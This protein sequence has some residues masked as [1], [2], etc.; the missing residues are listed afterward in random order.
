MRPLPPSKVPSLASS[1][2]SSPPASIASFRSASPASEDEHVI[3]RVRRS[4]T[5]LHPRRPR[6][7]SLAHLSQR[8]QA[9]YADRL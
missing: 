1:P 2:S 9:I 8:K 6:A 7:R 3:V 5:P 4:P